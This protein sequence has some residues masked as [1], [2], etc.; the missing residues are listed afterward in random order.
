MLILYV[1]V[2]K[3]LVIMGGVRHDS[4]IIYVNLIT[5]RGTR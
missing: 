3:C 4:Q 2:F 1:H 5:Y